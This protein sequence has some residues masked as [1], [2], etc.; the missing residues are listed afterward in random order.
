M[1]RVRRAQKTHEK[2]EPGPARDT[3]RILIADPEALASAITETIRE[4]FD[5]NQTA[6]AKSVSIPRTTLLRLAKSTDRHSSK[7]GTRVS[8]DVWRKL[9]V[10]LSGRRELDWIFLTDEAGERLRRYSTW[11]RRKTDIPTG[12]F[13]YP[14]AE[15]L[16]I[17]ERIKK[18]VPAVA[19]ALLRWLDSH[20][21]AYR[22]WIEA[23]GGRLSPEK[24]Y[25]TGGIRPIRCEV[26]ILRMLDPLLQWDASGRIERSADELSSE[27]FRR[28]IDQSWRREEITLNR[29]G[30]TARA[31]RHSQRQAK[32]T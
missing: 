30:D 24:R 28:F 19:T 10:F 20:E 32:K 11:L 23:L 26:M 16:R 3:A 7:S 6:A 4:K 2:S 1:D 17:L 29:E 18:E 12:E 5:G 22:A 13:R 8:I 25:P 21:I 31:Q 27:E 14:A 9:E 15:L